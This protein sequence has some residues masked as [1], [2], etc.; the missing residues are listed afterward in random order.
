MTFELIFIILFT[1]REA[2]EPLIETR[3]FKLGLYCKYLYRK[4]AYL[5]KI[6]KVTYGNGMIYLN[7][8][9]IGLAESNNKIKEIN[10]FV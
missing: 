8:F 1:L 5:K 10:N 2:S 9:I 6:E 7:Y 4:F 3:Q